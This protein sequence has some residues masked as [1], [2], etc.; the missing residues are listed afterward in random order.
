MVER[1]GLLAFRV[2]CKWGLSAAS[3][4]GGGGAETRAT[5]LGQLP[6]LDYDVAILL[7]TTPSPGFSRTKGL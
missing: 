3:D 1:L 6:S 4:G 2:L 5:R 7:V